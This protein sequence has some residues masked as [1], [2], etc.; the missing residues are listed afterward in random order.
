MQKFPGVS[1]RKKRRRMRKEKGTSRQKE[2]AFSGRFLAGDFCC[3]REGSI[4][5]PLAKF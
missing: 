3:W 5:S 1:D 2:Q 4:V